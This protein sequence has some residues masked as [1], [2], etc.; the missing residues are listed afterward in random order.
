MIHSDTSSSTI[1]PGQVK[2]NPTVPNICF[3]CVVTK[4]LC[5]IR[6]DFPALNHVS[7]LIMRKHRPRTRMC[8][9]TPGWWKNGTGA[10]Y[11]NAV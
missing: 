4:D 8:K 2:V 11:K 1:V 10:H 9:L 7:I 5:F 6:I 3:C